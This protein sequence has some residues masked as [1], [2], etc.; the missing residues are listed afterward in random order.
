ME[1]RYDL[2]CRIERGNQPTPLCDDAAVTAFQ[3]VRELLINVVKHAGVKQATVYVTRRENAVVINVED[4]GRG[5]GAGELDLSRSHGGGFGLFSLRERLSWLGGNLD[6]H[7]RP[8]GGTSS[9]VVIPVPS[10][11]ARSS[12]NGSTLQPSE[13]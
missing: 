8:G 10:S 3:A 13:H 11:E 7:S 4:K 5:F 12:G 6:M 9:Q 2:V 1:E